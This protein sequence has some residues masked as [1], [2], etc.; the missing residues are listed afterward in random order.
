MSKPYNKILCIDFETRWDSKDY[1]LTK[2]TTE[3]YVRDKRFKA[4][5]A[6]LHEIGRAHV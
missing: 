4:F 5:G 3:E 2:M 1:T 6:V